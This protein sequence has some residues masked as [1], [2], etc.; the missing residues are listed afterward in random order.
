VTPVRL[1]P[2]VLFATTSLL[3]LKLVDISARTGV[4]LEPVTRAQAE[5]STK[6][7]QLALAPK[8][9]AEP[10]AEKGA[11]GHGAPKAEGEPQGTVSTERPPEQPP[12]PPEIDPAEKALL[13][14][15][16]E[17]RAELEGR[18][19]DVEA[20]EQL[21]KAAEARVEDRL[22]ELQ[23]LEAKLSGPAKVDEEA[24]KAQISGLITMYENMRAKDAA[25]I[26]SKLDLKVLVAMVQRM[27]P[28]KMADILAAMDSEP[29]GRLTAEIA[30][31]SSAPAPA[32]LVDENDLPKIEGLPPG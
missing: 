9:K 15:L 10:A 12:A 17:R 16:Q 30:A 1:L 29:A 21:L 14:R 25:R 6:P 19:R 22:R 8:K 5:A 13:Q 28:R 3:V 4:A 24:A 2:V 20:R 23:S 32:P 26:M 27:N 18:L 31:R 11:D 7:I